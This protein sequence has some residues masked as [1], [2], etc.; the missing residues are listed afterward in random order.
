MELTRLL[1]AVLAGTM[2]LTACDVKDAIYTARPMVAVSVT[3][4]LC[5]GKA[6][7]TLTLTG[8]VE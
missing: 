8:G 2:L 7:G 6:P 1:F 5:K 4:G 3:Y